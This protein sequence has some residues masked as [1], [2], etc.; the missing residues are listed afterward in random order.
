MQVKLERV[1]RP[2]LRDR[3]QGAWFC[4]R[5]V[6]GAITLLSDPGPGASAAAADPSPG[7]ANAFQHPGAAALPRKPAPAAPAAEDHS[8]SSAHASKNPGAGALQCDPRFTAPVTP[9]LG[10]CPKRDAGALPVRSPAGSEASAGNSNVS[11]QKARSGDVKLT[12]Q[13]PYAGAGHSTSETGP[14]KGPLDF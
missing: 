12:V 11:Y 14:R 8:P 1:E 10:M 2:P 5:A 3:V 13:T 6:G 7:P 4:Y 9:L